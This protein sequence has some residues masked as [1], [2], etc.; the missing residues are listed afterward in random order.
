MLRRGDIVTTHGVFSIDGVV[1]R[2]ARD[3]SWVDVRWWQHTTG[4]VWVKR[5]L[6]QYR[7]VQLLKR[8]G[9]QSDACERWPLRLDWNPVVSVWWPETQFTL[10]DVERHHQAWADLLE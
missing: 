5:Q 10:A 7:G 8:L 3:G 6:T 9:N 1:L 4:K 2:A